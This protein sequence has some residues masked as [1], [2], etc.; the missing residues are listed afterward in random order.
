VAPRLTTH[1]SGCPE[2]AKKSRNKAKEPLQ[3]LALTGHDTFS[4]VAPEHIAFCDQH[5]FFRAQVIRAIEQIFDDFISG[6]L[7]LGYL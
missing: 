2:G 4:C 1:G 7:V 5:G 6:M 3:A